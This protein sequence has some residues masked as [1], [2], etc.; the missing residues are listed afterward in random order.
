M[1]TIPNPRDWLPTR[2]TGE[3]LY[4]TSIGVND[5][6]IQE[7]KGVLDEAVAVCEERGFAIQ[8]IGIPGPALRALSDVPPDVL[9]LMGQYHGIALYSQDDY[10]VAS[11]LELA[12]NL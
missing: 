3:R 10:P 1:A 6:T 2:Q 7:L 9:G 12:F 5:L 11:V 8:G 4:R